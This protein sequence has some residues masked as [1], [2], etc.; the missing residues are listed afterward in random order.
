MNLNDILKAGPKFELK[1]RVGRGVGSGMGK[2]STRGQKGHGAR[3][4]FHGKLGFEGGQMPL[5]RRL[6]KRGFNN[7][8]F[9]T[10][11]ST[12]NVGDLNETFKSGDEVSIEIL[13]ARGL[14]NSGPDELKVLG[15]GE[16]KIKLTVKACK[17]TGTASQKIEGA[18]GKAEQIS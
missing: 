8:R 9:R 13:R 2:T 3:E 10:E 11:Y 17:F 18:G 6:P 15:G 1:R 7:K 4:S 12:I 5:F 14:I 16:L